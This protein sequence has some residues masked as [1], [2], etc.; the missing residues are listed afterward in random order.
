MTSTA[1]AH[2]RVG[3]ALALC[4]AALL[5]AGCARPPAFS[6]APPA[7]SVADVHVRAPGQEGAPAD[8]TSFMLRPL[9]GTDGAVLQALQ[10]A[11][12][13]PPLRYRV[14]VVPGSGCAGLAPI[15]DRYFAGLLHAQVLVLHKPGVDPRARTAP[16]DCTRGFVQQD[17]LS[18]WL[19]HARAALRADAVQRQGEPALPLVLV[20]IS[21]GAELL[22]SLA[23]AVQG[24]APVAALVLLS[25]SGLDPREAGALQAERLGAS[26]DWRRIG[27]AVASPAPDSQA[28]QGRSLGYWRDLWA[29]PL[30]QPLRDGPWPLLQTWGDAD[31]LV[32][33]AAY[34]A[35]AQRMQGRAAP[36][37]VLR[38]SGA[39]HGLQG[40]AGD[41]VQR[42][43]A[44]LEAWA[45]A[46]AR[47]L[48]A[49]VPA[50]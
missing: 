26:A 14:V 2:A 22:P 43:W 13:T 48:C 35:F 34:E 38:L 24:T 46:P 49:P 21:E 30:A 5:L 28:L 16:G 7:A 15:A 50:P 8:A 18:T 31:A 17:R 9:P 32:P 27:Q 12:R 1:P 23:T 41:G 40:P 36:W 19:A 4:V 29:W 42:V 39:D 11:E 10:R 37:C 45:R 6:A 33:P 3:P 44:R 47:G 25:G 20:G